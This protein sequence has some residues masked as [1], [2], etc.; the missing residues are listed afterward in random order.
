MSVLPNPRVADLVTLGPLVSFHSNARTRWLFRSPKD[1]VTLTRPPE[2]NNAPCFTALV[3]SSC[4]TRPKGVAKSGAS[5]IGSPSIR[6]WSGFLERHLLAF[7]DHGAAFYAGSGNDCFRALQLA[8]INV[9]N[10]PTLRAF[11]QAYSIALSN[12]EVGAASELLAE[13]TKRWGSAAFQSSP[14]LVKHG[15]GRLEGAPA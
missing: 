7:A 3:A 5:R 13:A 1:Q 14:L 8:R 11:E 15:S 2:V 12:A 6:R 4:R 10:R 9:A